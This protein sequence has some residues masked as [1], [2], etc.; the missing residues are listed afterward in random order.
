MPFNEKMAKK[1]KYKKARKNPSK[2]VIHKGI[3]DIDFNT[4]DDSTTNKN[5]RA[6][7]HICKE[8][9]SK[10]SPVTNDPTETKMYFCRFQ[11]HGDPY[12]KL[13]PFKVEEVFNYPFI[14]LFHDFLKDEESEGLKDEASEN[15]SLSLL[16][17]SRGEQMKRS[18]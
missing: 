16:Q 10:N 3:D 12:L 13:G 15:L 14:V 17:G 11:H 8:A 5:D 9:H 18:R 2:R 7:G 1:K 6:L 4:L